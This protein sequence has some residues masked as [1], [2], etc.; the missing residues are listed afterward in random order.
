MIGPTIA[1]LDSN[2]TLTFFFFFYMRSDFNM[3]CL[4]TL[5]ADEDLNTQVEK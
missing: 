1:Y 5:A 2:C 3:L 4:K